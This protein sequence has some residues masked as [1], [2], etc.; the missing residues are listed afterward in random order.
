MRRLLPDPDPDVDLFDALRPPALAW[1]RLDFVAS[2]DGA[3]V[4]D[5]GRSG[6]L[7]GPGDRAVFRMLRAH[8]DAILVG[9]GTARDE[10][11]G[12]HRMVPELSARR[13]AE[14]RTDPA[15]IVVVTRSL[16]LDLSSPLFA[17][18]V[19]PTVVLTCSAASAAGRA[20]VVEAGGEV[21]VAGVDHVDL[22]EGAELLRAHGLASIV[23]EGGP[24]LAA[25]LVDAGL[26][27]ELCLTIAPM[28]MGHNGPRMVTALAG[29]APFALTRVLESDSELYLG[30]EA[31]RSVGPP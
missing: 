9:A 31:R 23:C 5:A 8:A 14:G 16:E 20:A 10:R 18:A 30:Y 12:P 24:R 6:G 21:V 7:G 3:V 29:R 1:L 17:E 13:A 27:D 2:L 19:A 11:Y 26:V 15:A 22:V 4:D 25:D 28:L